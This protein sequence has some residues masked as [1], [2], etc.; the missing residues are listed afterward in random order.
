[1]G[2]IS[3]ADGVEFE[4]DDCVKTEQGGGRFAKWHVFRLCQWVLCCFAGKDAGGEEFLDT[5]KGET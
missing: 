3:E 5:C 4:E 1:M 2:W